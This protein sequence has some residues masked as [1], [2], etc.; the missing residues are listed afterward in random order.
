VLRENLLNLLADLKALL[1][2]D[3]HPEAVRIR[4]ALR[5]VE[6]H[7]IIRHIPVPKRWRATKESKL[8]FLVTELLALGPRVIHLVS[9]HSELPKPAEP[10]L[11]LPLQRLKN[12]L[13]EALDAFADCVASKSTRHDLPTLDRALR[14]TD[15][16]SQQIHD[17]KI[18]ISYPIDML[19]LTLDVVARHRAVA[20]AVNKL[21]PVMADPK[22]HRYWDDYAL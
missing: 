15:E 9:L 18:L 14:E 7:Q 17:Q 13:V 16:A 20:D 11:R 10:F 4:L 22:I 2:G 6:T 12:S 3:P 19:L 21:L 5:S 1:S 8:N